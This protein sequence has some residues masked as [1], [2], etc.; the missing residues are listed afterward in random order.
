[1][2]DIVEQPSG[3]SDFQVE[4]ARIFFSLPAA[5]SFLLAGGAAL[6]AQHLTTRPTQDL[7]FFTQPSTGTV[8]KVR[9]EFEAAAR[10]QGWAV[11]YIRDTDMFCRL[12]VHGRDDLLVDIAV[13][14]PPTSPAVMSHFGPTLAPE[15]LAGR[16]LVA[17]FDRAEARDFA[18]VYV[19]VQR[20]GKPMLLEQ[21]RKVDAGLDDAVLA[22]MMAR[23]DRF[24]DD[25]IP[26]VREDL[27]KLR[28]LFEEWQSELGRRS[29]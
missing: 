8:T 24:D 4:V 13:D 25:E 14:S 10:G 26:V 19:L 12:V 2:A 28:R 23:L 22:E 27:P 5:K 7:D 17:L 3:L 20:F 16:K 18:D 9:D 6:V 15:E 21:A 1:M 29:A 11:E